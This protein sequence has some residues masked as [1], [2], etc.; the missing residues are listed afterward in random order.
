MKLE[1]SEDAEFDI[2]SIGQHIALDDARIAR[3]FLA[4]LRAFIETIADHPE[5]YRPRL[6]WGRDVRAARFRNYLVIYEHSNDLVTVLRV[7]NGY[8][9][10]PRLL[11]DTKR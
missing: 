7:A 1:Y 5:L 10:I 2:V 8:R 9:D 6:E 4:D 11:D 3:G